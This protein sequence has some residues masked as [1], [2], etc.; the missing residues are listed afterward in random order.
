MALAD[1]AAPPL[2]APQCSKLDLGNAVSGQEETTTRSC[3]PSFDSPNDCRSRRSATALR[4]SEIDNG[5]R[6]TC[7]IIRK[8]AE[9]P[10]AQC[11]KD[12]SHLPTG[13]AV[14]DMKSPAVRAVTRQIA[15]N[16]AAPALAR[17]DSVVIARL[18][19]VLTAQLALASL[20][21]RAGPPLRPEAVLAARQ[22]G[23]ARAPMPKTLNGLAHMAVRTCLLN[24]VAPG[25]PR[26]H[27]VALLTRL[28]PR[29]QAVAR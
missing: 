3:G 26:T 6:Q 14:I 7:Y 23:P 15:A 1:A 2:R 25:I 5:A 20:L 16:R 13:V 28:A 4:L 21:G 11:A 18:H 24:Q 22:P 10:V 27:G 12:A 19:A 8:Q 17:Q 29:A 9:A